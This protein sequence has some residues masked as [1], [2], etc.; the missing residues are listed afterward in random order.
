[1]TSDVAVAGPWNVIF[2]FI[3]DLLPEAGGQAG[4][5]SIKQ[6]GEA[7]VT[8]TGKESVGSAT[9]EIVG[10][11]V[12]TQVVKFGIRHLDT[13]TGTVTYN[14]EIEFNIDSYNMNEFSGVRYLGD[15]SMEVDFDEMTFEGIALLKK[16]DNSL[17][18]LVDVGTV[19]LA[20]TSIGDNGFKGVFTL[21][22]AVRADIGLTGNPVGNY[23]G[24]F[25]HFDKD[26]II[27]VMSIIGI[28]TN[29]A[30]LGIGN[31]SRDWQFQNGQD[32]SYSL[33][34]KLRWERYLP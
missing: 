13:S 32:K 30:V 34:M 20:S 4:K 10:G 24:N 23:A 1:M 25:T 21:D 18:E 6:G 27:G 2:K 5:Q 16:Y 14:G 15:L 3:G 7:A 22:E 12:A 19:T 28:T 29:G 17:K 8:Q 9:G 11:R 31:F 33:E 26:D